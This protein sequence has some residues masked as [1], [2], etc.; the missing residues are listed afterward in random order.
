MCNRI[1]QKLKVK[2]PILCVYDIEINNLN[3]NTYIPI[4]K[5]KI[6]VNCTINIMIEFKIWLFFCFT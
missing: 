2:C 4:V 5:E 3:T 6:D 1:I